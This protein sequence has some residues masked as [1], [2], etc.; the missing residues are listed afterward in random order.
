MADRI[1]GERRKSIPDEWRHLRE[2]LLRADLQF[3]RLAP[4]FDLWP[5][6]LRLVERM[7]T[8][9]DA[10]DLRFSDCAFC[11]Q[12]AQEPAM[13]QFLHLDRVLSYFSNCIVEGKTA[14]AFVNWCHCKIDF[15][16]EPS[17]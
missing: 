16:A 9:D 17:I 7:Q 8:R 5:G 3:L 12:F 1:E 10:V 4:L 2:I 6:S 14:I 15:R 13:R 11:E